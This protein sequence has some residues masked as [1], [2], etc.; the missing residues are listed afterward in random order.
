MG[1]S[2]ARRTGSKKQEA[3]HWQPHP[4]PYRQ[5]P[6]NAKVEWEKHGVMNLRDFGRNGARLRQFQRGNR[7]GDA[8][9]IFKGDF[10]GV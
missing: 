7:K 8:L 9:M 5:G 6:K 10:I 4:C 3:S 2:F 1:R